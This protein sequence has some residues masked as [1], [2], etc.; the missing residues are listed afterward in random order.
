MSG[1]TGNILRVNLTTGKIDCEELNRSWAQKYLGGKGL[2]IKYL[3]EE[4]PAKLAPLSPDNKIILMTGPFTGTIVPCSGKLAVI[5]KSPATGT[6]LDCSI[7]GHFAGELKYSGYDAVIIEGKASQPSYLY[8]EDG[9]VEIRHAGSLWG[10]GTHDTEYALKEELGEDAKILSIGPAGEN[11]VPMACITSELYRQAGR[12]G[13]GAVM[14]SKNL[15]AVAVKG[16]GSVKV[17]N[18]KLLMETVNRIMREDTL[19]DTNLWAYTDGT[20]MLVDLSN[21]TG[22][23]PTR[24][25]QDGTFEGHQK[26]NSEAMKNA[27]AGKKGCLSCALGCGNYSRVGNS[28]VEGPEYE[29]LALA[30]S[31]CGIDDLQAIVKFNYLCDDLGLDTISCGNTIAFVMEMTE[32]GIKDFG[33]TFGDTEKYLEIP[34]LIATRKGIGA[35]LAQGVKALSEKYGGRE[36]AMHVKGLEFPGYD[37]R[38]SWGMG[39]AYAT[40]DRGACHLRAWPIAEEAYGQRDPFTIEGKA[41]LVVDL[42]HYNAIKFS[43]ILCDFWALSLAT[44]AEIASVVL[45]AEISESDLVTA[46]ER[47]VNLARLFNWREG[48]TKKDDTLP[49]RV[50]N[51]ALKSGVT[52]GKLIPE[53]EFQRMLEEYYAIRGWDKEGKPRE[54]KLKSLNV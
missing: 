21:S 15:K 24:N 12:G 25:Y 18:M 50:F 29:T 20:A 32:K 14:G 27:R 44:L 26:I 36:F 4:L 46:G 42:Q 23:L 51:D 7:G 5:T 2:G 10:K 30:G 48:F 28:A 52:A 3:Y 9:R 38:G 11:L 16:S 45:G 54:D 39:L 37:P 6:I 49:A 17:K 19:T 47:I 8:I 43:A 53:Q 41:Q 13:V 22:V 40:A 1:Y 31:N 34:E 35:E 33:I